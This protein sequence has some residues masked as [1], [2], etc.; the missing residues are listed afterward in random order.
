MEKNKEGG[1]VLKN[2]T[3]AILISGPAFNESG[4]RKN[5]LMGD[6]ED[7]PFEIGKNI[8]SCLWP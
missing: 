5:F 7:D 8:L 1:V 6:V 3:K 2:R 4:V